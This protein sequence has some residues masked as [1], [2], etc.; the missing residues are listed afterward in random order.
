MKSIFTKG[1]VKF[2]AVLFISFYLILPVQAVIKVA[3]IGNSITAGS[4]IA[5]P[6]AD[7][8]PAVLGR[9]LGSDYQVANYGVSGTTM[10]RKGNSPYWATSNY[11]N[12]KAFKPDI[13]IIKL[14]TNDSKVINLAYI[15]EFETDMSNMVDTFRLL[16]SRPKVY[17]CIPA[18]VFGVGGYGITDAAELQEIIPRIN[19]VVAAKATELIN[20]RV[21]LI[22]HP[23]LFPDNIHPNVEGAKILAGTAYKALTGLDYVFPVITPKDIYLS[24]FGSD[25]NDG[26]TPNTPVAT[27]YKA[28]SLSL[29]TT[30]DVIHVSGIIDVSTDPRMPLVSA[31]KAGYVINKNVSIIGESLSTDGFDGKNL[32][33]IF[34]LTGSACTQSFKNLTIKNG[35][36]LLAAGSGGAISIAGSSV[37]FENLVFDNNNGFDGTSSGG[38][39]YVNQSSGLNFKNCIFSNNS[40]ISGGALCVFD[41]T[42]TNAIV[43]IEACSFF[44][45]TSSSS[46][47]AIFIRMP[48]ATA[49]NTVNIINSTFTNNTSQKGSIFIYSTADLT[50]TVNITNCTI[51]GNK[52]YATAGCSGIYVLNSLFLGKLNINN[53]IVEGN[54]SGISGTLPYYDIAFDNITPTSSTLMI[55]NSFIGRNGSSKVVPVECY[56]GFDN[57]PI[58]NYF[59]YITSTSTAVNLKAKLSNYNE[60]LKCF[61]L[62]ANSQ[63]IKFGT[64]SYL[65]DLLVSTDQ[66][67]TSR[68]Y[69]NG[70]CNAGAIESTEENLP[71]ALNEVVMSNGFKV[72]QKDHSTIAVEYK[73]KGKVTVDLFS[74]LGQNVQS[75]SLSDM[76]TIQEIQLDNIKKGLYIVKVTVNGHVFNQKIF[77]R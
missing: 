77:I 11:Q 64:S 30:G 22:N 9:I 1:R 47:A 53:S 63:A 69:L 19:N 51:S 15:S 65:S 58:S 17:L 38:A 18:P 57:T 59:N 45:N 7:A 62:Q 6:S 23:E 10:L 20:F 3:C 29:A 44:N 33:R 68:S 49:H 27:F 39:I 2:I 28:Y 36:Y 70:K 76:S 61:P 13:V 16:S 67:G 24:S 71:S 32:T 54:Y 5:N 21:P 66:L 46:G 37:N 8:Y 43:R 31:V 72:Y 42:T 26:L 55:H 73:E 14:G 34:Q 75:I 35:K 40:A 52:S 4:G 25:T 60:S 41:L 12:A 74:I 50:A 48:G 56:P